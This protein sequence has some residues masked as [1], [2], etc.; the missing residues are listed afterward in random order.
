MYTYIHKGIKIPLQNMYVLLFIIMI[1]LMYM[2][3]MMVL[4]GNLSKI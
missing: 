4:G 2:R 3:Y 1:N